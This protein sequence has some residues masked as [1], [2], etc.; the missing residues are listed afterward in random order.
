[1]IITGGFNVYPKE[2][3]D[4]IVKLAQIEDVAVVGTQD[5][6]WGEA[7]CAVIVTQKTSAMNAEMV[8]EHVK[9]E[10]GSIAAPKH[11]FVQTHPLPTTP[12]GK[13]DKKQVRQLVADKVHQKFNKP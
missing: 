11:V 10:L 7:V 8:K 6:H 5:I 1:M 9:K 13:P 3:E 2:V 4:A 12:L